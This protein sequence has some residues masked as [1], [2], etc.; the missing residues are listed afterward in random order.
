MI[1]YHDLMDGGMSWRI[2]DHD[3]RVACLLFIHFKLMLMMPIAG[4]LLQSI[5]QK[6]QEFPATMVQRCKDSDPA[7]PNP[8]A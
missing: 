3:L 8:S 6:F 2:Q 5:S 4:C 1:Q 7:S